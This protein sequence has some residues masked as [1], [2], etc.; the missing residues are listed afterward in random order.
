[1]DW[2][3]DVCSS[4]LGDDAAAAPAG[5]A[6][7][8][9]LPA[10]GRPVRLL[11]CLPAPGHL[12]GAGPGQLLAADPRGHRRTALHHGGFLRLAAAPAAGADLD[13]R[14][15]APPGPAL[16]PPA[17]GRLRRRGAGGAA[18]PLAGQ[19]RPA[20]AAAVC[21]DPGTAAG[22]APVVALAPGTGAGRGSADPRRVDQQ[23]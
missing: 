16:G 13:P 8:D 6:L 19:G 7:A 15:D 1:R 12:S 20:R 11:L 18:L 23:G 14:L 2:S 17:Q 21:G 5:Q 4:D 22:P 3:S 9:P 10:P